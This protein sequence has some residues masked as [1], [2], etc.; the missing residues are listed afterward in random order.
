MAQNIKRHVDVM[1]NENI[2]EDA[3]SFVCCDTLRL[4]TP[5]PPAPPP[6]DLGDV[7]E[8]AV[9]AVVGSGVE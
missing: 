4:I 1:E 3:A 8:N 9:D 5:R 2:N 7:K 6:T